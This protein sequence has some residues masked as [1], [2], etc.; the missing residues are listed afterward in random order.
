VTSQ[1]SAHA[2]F[3]RRVEAGQTEA[4][5]LAALELRQI[6]LPDALDL[7]ALLAKDRD[8]RFPRAAARW[9][10]RYAR[11][12]NLDQVQLAAAALSHLAADPSSE[13]A[14]QTLRRLI[15]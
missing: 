15:P 5:W 14:A 8:P 1:G 11:D 9:L 13:V 6:S 7:C 10:A 2:R 4:A 3:R 12:A